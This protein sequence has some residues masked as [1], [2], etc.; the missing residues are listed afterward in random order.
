LASVS[1]PTDLKTGRNRIAVLPLVFDRTPTIGAVGHLHPTAS[2]NDGHDG[3]I[4]TGPLAQI[5]S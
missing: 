2:W 3:R 1:Y 5:E 4:D